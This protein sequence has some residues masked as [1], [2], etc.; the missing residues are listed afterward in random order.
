MNKV[1]L[2]Q[3]F[4]LIY[5]FFTCYSSSYNCSIP[6]YPPLPP[7]TQ[8]IVIPRY[9]KMGTHLTDAALGFLQNKEVF[10]I[11][12]DGIFMKND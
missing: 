12:I 1:A 10:F 8:H 4:L 2:E 9:L 3:V 7:T 6:I 11:G 5:S